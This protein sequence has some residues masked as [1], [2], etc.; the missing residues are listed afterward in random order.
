MIWQLT[1]CKKVEISAMQRQQQQHKKNT[2]TRDDDS[3]SKNWD[4]Y[5]LLKDSFADS[6]R[7]L[8]N[9]LGVSKSL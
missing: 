7:I 3:S 5:E 1:Y 9:S 8:Q 4:I 6:C 2:G